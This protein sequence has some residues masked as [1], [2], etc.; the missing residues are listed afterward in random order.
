M[1]FVQ[2]QNLEVG[3]RFTEDGD[4]NVWEVVEVIDST[5]VMAQCLVS[6][7]YYEFREGNHSSLL[8]EKMDDF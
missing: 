4:P 8:L 7:T 6:H 3:D 1:E 5:T 2:L